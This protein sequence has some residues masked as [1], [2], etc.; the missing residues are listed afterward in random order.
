MEVIV[1]EI[2]PTLVRYKLFSEPKGRVYFVY[3]DDVAGIMYQNGRV[4]TF[5]NQSGEKSIETKSSSNQSQN[6]YQNQDQYQNQQPNSIVRNHG[7]Y[8][9]SDN[10]N[11]ISQSHNSSTRQS[12]SQFHVGLAF[13]LGN[14][15]GGNASSD[16]FL[17]AGKG[18][19]AMGFTAGYKYYSPLPAENLSW[20]LGIE[21]FYNGIN[22][23]AKDEADK[24]GLDYISPMYFNYCLSP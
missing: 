17:S 13:P 23:D 15:A 24:I 5:N 10:Y 12:F 16:G 14:F 7:N 2:T 1:T 6:Q 18:F 8:E 9:T 22:S 21:A 4:E 20:V 3:K 11:S 19:A